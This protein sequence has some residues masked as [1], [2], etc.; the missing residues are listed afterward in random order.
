MSKKFSIIKEIDLDKLR[1]QIENYRIET[2][3]INP[4]IFMNLDT[5]E[6]ISEEVGVPVKTFYINGSMIGL[7]EGNNV[8]LHEGLKYGEVEIR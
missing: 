2:G 6:Q 1:R 4:Y 7:F 8:F 3:E 5:I